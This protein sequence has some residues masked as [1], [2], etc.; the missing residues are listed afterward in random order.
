MHHAATLSLLIAPLLLCSVTHGQEP[1]ESQQDETPQVGPLQ[2]RL[3]A[4]Y[5]HQFKTDIDADSRYRVD[6]FGLNVGLDLPVHQQLTFA[7]DFGYQHDAYRFSGDTGFSGGDAW[8]DVNTLTL[9]AG[10]S[11]WINERWQIFGGPYIRFSG[12]EGANFNDSITVGGAF[13]VNHVV[14]EGL[15]LGLGLGI[16]SQIEDSAA[17]F[18]IAVVRWSIDEQWSLQTI[19]G[20]GAAGGGGIELAYALDP[21]WEVGVGVRYESRRFRLDKDNTAAPRGVG[22]ERSLPVGL[23]LSH[24]P[25]PD[26]VVELLGGVNLRPRL[27]LEDEHGSRI[28]RETADAAPFVAIRASIAF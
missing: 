1:G 12:E 28:D 16:G 22:D 5:Q 9:R 10:A 2:L 14:R 23:R 11:Y 19:G 6:R 3:G 4:G 26:A 7:V 8:G 13:G 15:V 17:F 24:R 21:A 27:T 25:R 20:F 18:P